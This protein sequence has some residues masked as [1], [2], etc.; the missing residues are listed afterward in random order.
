MMSSMT[1]QLVTTVANAAIGQ[2]IYIPGSWLEPPGSARIILEARVDNYQR[3][4]G[5]R[6]R[7]TLEL[8]QTGQRGVTTVALEDTLE[9][10]EYTSSYHRYRDSHCEAVLASEVQVG[11]QLSWRNVRLEVM[12]S[13]P[14]E[15]PSSGPGVVLE[16]KRHSDNGRY[17]IECDATTIVPVYFPPQ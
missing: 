9:I 5:H 15:R 6:R 1:Q 2:N 16:I 7:L 13:R 8:L 12:A 4:D 10:F 3:L 14:L 11:D 17:T